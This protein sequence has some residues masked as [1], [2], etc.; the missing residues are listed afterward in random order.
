MNIVEQVK[1]LWEYG[2]TQKVLD[3]LCNIPE[4]A[5]RA[6]LLKSLDIKIQTPEFACLNRAIDK[7]VDEL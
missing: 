3:L 5:E 7:L 2:F 6:K 4:V 1:Y